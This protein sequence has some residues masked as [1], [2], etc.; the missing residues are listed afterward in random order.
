MTSTTWNK[1][2]LKC[3]IVLMVRWYI[4]EWCLDALIVPRA[5]C[6]PVPSQTGGSLLTDSSLEVRWKT[7]HLNIFRFR[8]GRRSRLRTTRSPVGIP[9]SNVQWHWTTP[10]YASKKAPVRKTNFVARTC[11]CFRIIQDQ[12]YLFNFSPI[13]FKV[14]TESVN[15]SLLFKSKLSIRILCSLPYC[16]SDYNTV[17]IAFSLNIDNLT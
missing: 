3:W 16:Y 4:I 6:W 7:L 2:I 12:K 13:S 5:S 17:D 15:G 10:I 11:V 8:S 14:A 9:W 1:F